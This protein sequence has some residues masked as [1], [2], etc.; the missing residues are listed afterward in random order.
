MS[1]FWF[2]MRWPHILAMALFLGGQIFLSQTN[3]AEATLPSFAAGMA[4]PQSAS[5]ITSRSAPS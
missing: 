5:E 1:H 3:T 4:R 2:V